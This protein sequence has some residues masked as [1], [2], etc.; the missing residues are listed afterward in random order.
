MGTLRIFI[1]IL[2]FFAHDLFTRG[3]FTAND[4]M[5]DIPYIAITFI[6]IETGFIVAQQ[7]K[8][9]TYKTKTQFWISR[10][11]R[12]I[13]PTYFCLAI[14]VILAIFFEI[15]PLQ[16]L[17]QKIDALAI[18]NSLGVDSKILFGMLNL[19]L[20]QSLFFDM[21]IVDNTL[22]WGNGQGLRAIM[23]VLNPAYW[24]ISSD[25]IFMLIMPIIL[26]SRYKWLVYIVGIFF[27]TKQYLVYEDIG[28][29]ESMFWQNH[30]NAFT[31]IT[32]GYIFG[33]H[34]KTNIIKSKLKS[35][36]IAIIVLSITFGFT[37]YL[38]FKNINGF[39]LY[40]SSLIG[41]SIS[42]I[43]L[44]DAFAYNKI[45]MKCR[46]IANYSYLLQWPILST[47]YSYY[48]P[49][50]NNTIMVFTTLV[51]VSIFLAVYLEKINSYMIKALLR[52]TKC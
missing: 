52:K 16:A 2:V 46:D 29:S 49:S 25:I 42:S 20:Q 48:N 37:I 30:Y 40:L 41:F 47:F 1:A 26:Y 5:S 34:T 27:I 28:F 44:W 38:D 13:I 11:F 18:Y 3:I 4:K 39:S 23:L 15:Q 14:S 6:F 35:L 19:T 36:V 9:K 31:A 12:I 32:L 51:I 43:F 45:D 10:L 8:N 33:M 24:S 21:Q 17:R 7:I 50:I 22:V